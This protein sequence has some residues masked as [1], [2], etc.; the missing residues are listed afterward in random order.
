MLTEAMQDRDRAL[1][2]HVEQ[3]RALTMFAA[4]IA[5]ELKNP[6]ASIKGLG[7]LVAKDVQG[8]TG[9]RMTVLRGEVDRMQAALEEFLNFSRPLAPI[10]G[11]P[12]GVIG[13]WPAQT[14]S[15]RSQSAPSGNSRRAKACKAAARSGR[16]DGD[17]PSRSA[18]AAARRR[19]PRRAKTIFSERSVRLTVGAADSAGAVIE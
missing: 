10:S 3:S 19:S 17:Q 18:K 2:M 5:H 11:R 6:L 16:T 7:A 9:E 4:E 14:G 1:A 12:E 8:R 15:T 13:R